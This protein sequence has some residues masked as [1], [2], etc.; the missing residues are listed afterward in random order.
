MHKDG[1]NDDED[2]CV[3]TDK[4]IFLSHKGNVNLPFATTW[5]DI[6]GIALSK[7]SQ[8]EVDKYCM[9]CISMWL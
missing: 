7:I 9:A 8:T 5:V 2:M 4:R 1:D 6:G 3:H